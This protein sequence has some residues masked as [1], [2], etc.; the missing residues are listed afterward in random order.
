[1]K[2]NL[3]IKQIRNV[4]FI[5]FLIFATAM[6]SV[7]AG[8]LYAGKAKEEVSEARYS[9]EIEDFVNEFNRI[10]DN[11]YMEV[12][13][14]VLIKGAIKGMLE[15]LGDEHS[16]FLDEEENLR[17][18][19]RVRGSYE[20]IGIGLIDVGEDIIITAVFNNSPAARAGLRINDIIIKLD[21]QDYTDKTTQEVVDYIRGKDEKTVKVTVLRDEQELDF[22]VEIETVVLPS[23]ESEIIEREGFKIGYIRVSI[24]ALNTYS[25]F[26]THLEELEKEVDGLI[27]D[28][29][30]NTGG[31]LSTVEQMLGLFFDK[32]KVIYQTEDKDKIEKIYSKGDKDKPYPI[33][34]LG[35]QASASASEIMIA[36]MQE[37]YGAQFVGTIT[38]GKGTVQEL[39]DF[40]GN[41]AFKFTT[42]KWLTPN[43]NWID[44]EGIEPDYE[45][46]QSS[47]YFLE[48]DQAKDA[49]LQRAI[50]VLLDL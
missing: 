34:M 29:R 9:D 22:D 17:F 3:S 43:G 14:D 10:V 16:I 23:V 15:A 40:N 13:R 2:E 47:E 45:I 7:F 21:H 28:L 39:F 30:G 41:D 6:T 5:S 49:Q 4:L 48:F 27:I 12:D 11:F 24:F 20:G 50:N 46:E 1:M 33:V 32:D 38:Y 35:N 26:A 42:R 31:Y 8:Y 37:T 19:Q 25:Q 44:G 18:Q 36:A